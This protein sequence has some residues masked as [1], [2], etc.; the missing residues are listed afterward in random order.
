MK[1]LEAGIDPTFLEFEFTESS[2]MHDMDKTIAIL[3]K[4]CHKGISISIDDFGIA[5]ELEHSN[6]PTF[7][8][9][10]NKPVM[11]S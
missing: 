2:I 6:L 5:Y 7:R 4:L 8:M 10:E 9:N 1:W 11:C 3:E